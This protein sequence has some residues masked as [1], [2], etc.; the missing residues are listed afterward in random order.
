MMEYRLHF[1]A[2][3]KLNMGRHDQQQKTTEKIKAI[4]EG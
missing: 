3:I 4:Y 1:K 2:K